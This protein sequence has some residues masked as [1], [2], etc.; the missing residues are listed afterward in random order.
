MRTATSFY[1]CLAVALFLFTLSGA[2]I[3]AAQFNNTYYGSGALASDPTG[4]DADSAFGN[5]A[6]YSSTT[7]EYNTAVGA[8]A[9]SANTNG[10]GNTAVGAYALYS[11]D[12]EITGLGGYENTAAGENA[13]RS[14]TTGTNN[15][16]VGAYALL[17]NTTGGNNIGIGEGG[18]VFLTTGSNNIDIGNGGVSGAGES[19]TIRIG[20]QGQ[21]TATFFAGIY[22]E[23]VGKKHCTVLVDSDGKIGCGSS[24]AVDT[25]ML[26][27]E[28]RKQAAQIADMKASMRRQA[29]ELKA[30]HEREL[31][32]RTTFEERLSR[33]EQVMA[34]KNG[35]RNLAAAFNR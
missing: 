9:L 16:A 4:T 29:A 3:A 12:P 5:D 31:A 6:L 35:S 19:N 34:S 13:L 20:V 15:T 25:S 17:S 27:N 7:G 32:M 21:Q 22:E 26:L 24:K 18:G 30:S 8:S 11:N 2:G 23:K 14:N 10:D 1:F 28:L 33:L